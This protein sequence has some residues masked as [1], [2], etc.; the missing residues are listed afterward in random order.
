MFFVFSLWVVCLLGR[1]WE[2]FKMMDHLDVTFLK[3]IKLSFS[4][5]NILLIS[6]KQKDIYVDHL[7]CDIRKHMSHLD[8]DRTF[9]NFVLSETFWGLYTAQVFRLTLHITFKC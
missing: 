6:I 9:T 3:L 8:A 5:K 2:D 7:Y 1:D 4:K